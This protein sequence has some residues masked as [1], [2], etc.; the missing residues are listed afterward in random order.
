MAILTFV[1]VV[2][3]IVIVVKNGQVVREMRRAREQQLKPNIVLCFE[4]RRKGLMCF[5]L[6]NLGGSVVNKLSVDV[7]TEFIDS[8]RE[9]Y[10]T[11][12]RALKSVALTIVPNQE[13]IYVAGGP[14]D[15]GRIARVPLRGTIT[16]KDVFGRTNN[17]KFNVNVESYR[18]ALLYGPGL[19]ELTATIDKRLKFIA[20]YLG[21]DIAQTVDKFDE[22]M[23]K[24]DY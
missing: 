14:L 7:S 8:L 1:Y 10:Q 16:Y 2:A 4:L 5:V 21:D 6:R 11:K 19:D 18:G 13:V 17:E 15:F 24:E 9:E 20:D 23:R 22:A 3:T 12:F